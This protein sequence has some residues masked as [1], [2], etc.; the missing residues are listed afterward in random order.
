MSLKNTKNSEKN[1]VVKQHPLAYVIRFIIFNIIYFFLLATLI[2][3]LSFLQLDLDFIDSLT[4]GIVVLTVIIEILVAIYA[5]LQWRSIF[6]IIK[7]RSIVSKYG[8]FFTKE[9]IFIPED[10]LE[11]ILEQG[12]LAKIFNYGTITFNN[13]IIEENVYMKNIRDPLKHLKLC[14]EITREINK[15]DF[16]KMGNNK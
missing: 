12:L 7:D 10:V 11:I 2:G 8:V 6:Y 16:P 15:M 1:I 4:G 9:K 5:F 14:R 13:K 3:I